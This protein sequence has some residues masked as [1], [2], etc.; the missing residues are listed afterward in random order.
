MFC[1]KRISWDIR[2]RKVEY[3]IQYADARVICNRRVKRTAGPRNRKTKKGASGRCAESAA[4]ERKEEIFLVQ[5]SRRDRSNVPDLRPRP[6]TRRT[7]GGSTGAQ[8][9]L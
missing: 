6:M 4:K 7:R 8:G 9:T 1:V 2:R 3:R 5:G